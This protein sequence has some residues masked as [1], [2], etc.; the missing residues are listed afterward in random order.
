MLL[1][2]SGQLPYMRITPGLVP[3]IAVSLPYRNTRAHIGVHVE[4]PL[5]S[6][7]DPSTRV[8]ERLRVCSNARTFSAKRHSMGPRVE[9]R[10]TYVRV[11][12]VLLVLRL[13]NHLAPA[14][15]ISTWTRQ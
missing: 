15:C 4:P 7:R 12:D 2:R 1:R 10:P 3:Q 9:S 14:P 8:V 11:D 13:C 5:R 6:H